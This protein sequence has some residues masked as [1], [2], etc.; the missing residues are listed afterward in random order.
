MSKTMRATL[1]VAI[2]CLAAI[3][4]SSNLAPHAIFDQGSVSKGV[5]SDSRPYEFKGFNRPSSIL[6]IEAFLIENGKIRR[7]GNDR[8]FGSLL[9]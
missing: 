3:L 9:P 1:V 5:L 6:V 2:A 7:G 8:S 4:L